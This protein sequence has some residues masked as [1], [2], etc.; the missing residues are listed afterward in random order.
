MIKAKKSVSYKFPYA[1]Q[2][3]RFIDHF[4]VDVT[5]E[6]KDHTINDNEIASEHLAKMGAV[7]TSDGK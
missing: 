2:I 5:N 4:K 3:S 7:E 1:V 6:V